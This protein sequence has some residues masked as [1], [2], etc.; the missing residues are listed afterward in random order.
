MQNKNQNEEL[1]LF[2]EFC[3]EKFFVNF[4]SFI[5]YSKYHSVNLILFTIP[6]SN[7]QKVI[8]ICALLGGVGYGHCIRVREVQNL[9]R[10]CPKSESQ[11]FSWGTLFCLSTSQGGCNISK[12][13]QPRV[14]KFWWCSGDLTMKLASL[15]ISSSMSIT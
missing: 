3:H 1:R 8:T 11:N 9:H 15:I 10:G 13:V 2:E 5:L 12:A 4:S 7:Y 14:F 6:P